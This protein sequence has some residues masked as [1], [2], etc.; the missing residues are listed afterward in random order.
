M[1]HERRGAQY[2]GPQPRAQSRFSRRAVV[3]GAAALV[4]GPHRDLHATAAGPPDG[5]LAFEGRVTAVPD[6]RSLR[7]GD[8]QRVMLPHLLPPGPDRHAP[9]AD[10]T[11][12]RQA[13]TLLAD[14]TLGRRVRIDLLTPG[15]DR[16]GRLRA[17][18]T[19]PGGA[20]LATE[21]ASAGSV[22]VM[23]EPSADP[24]E[25][26]PLLEAERRARQAAAGFWARGLFRRAAARPYDGGK[27]RFEIVVG[28]VR[29]GARI[30]ARR[31]LEFGED[32]RTDFTA[33]LV[34]A[35]YRDAFGG[36]DAPYP[37]G[38]VLELRGWVRDW[39]GPFMEVGEAVQIRQL[40]YA[41]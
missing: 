31:H 14:R 36:T 1:R 6:G 21:L 9:M 24:A 13:A 22:R 38:S 5:P 29:G 40:S 30:G 26:A 11:P 37:I 16:H 17:R 15:R 12:I 25:V 3:V 32:W 23:P 18:V 2:A 4:L 10:T 27:D 34:S 33:G 19:L 28:T 8:G 35:A 41:P 7:L 20:D 39:N